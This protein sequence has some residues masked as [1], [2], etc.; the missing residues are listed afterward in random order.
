MIGLARYVASKALNKAKPTTAAVLLPRLVR[1][2]FQS[3]IGIARELVIRT[4]TIFNKAGM[5]KQDDFQ[6]CCGSDAPGSNFYT[7]LPCPT[8]PQVWFAGAVLGEDLL[9][10]LLVSSILFI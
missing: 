7:R 4:A 10:L 5:S 9:V 1:L 3:P 6:N 8:R 2:P